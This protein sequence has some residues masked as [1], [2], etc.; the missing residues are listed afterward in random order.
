[1]KKL[2]LIGGTMGVGKSA[3]CE[4]LNKK[5]P[6]SVY[7]DGDWCWNADPFVV[8]EE[9]KAMVHDNIAHILNSFIRCS[10]YK[11]II[12]CWVMHEQVIFDKIL[13]GI[14]ATCCEIISLSL[15]C[16]ETS[17]Q[18]RLE[19]DIEIGKRTADII[20]KSVVRLPL[21]EKLNTIKIDTTNKTVEAVVE[22][23]I[24]LNV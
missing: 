1:M 9:I 5:L 19:K 7:L 10:A 2:Y 23:I 11:N 14:E 16:D 21:Y 3:V 12:F 24:G 20:E 4:I 15:T 22:E 13:K 18:H 17:L 8:T 6:D